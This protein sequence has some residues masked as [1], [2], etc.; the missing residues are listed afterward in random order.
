MEEHTKSDL[1][2]LVQDFVRLEG[3][4][5][6]GIATTGTL[7]GGPPS[8]NIEY[9]LDRARSVVSF[10]VGLDTDSI[11][12]YLSKQDRRWFEREMIQANVIASGIALHLTNYL[13]NKGHRAEPV[14]ANL[15]Y[16]LGEGNESG[17]D[18]TTT[19]YPD[20]AHRYVA[21]RAGLGH[22]GKSGNF[23][24]PEYGAAVILG[25]VVTDA[26]LVP[27]PPLPPEAN[28][29]DGCGLCR[30]ACV[31]GFM[32]FDGEERVVLGGEEYTY[33]R[34]RNLARCDLVCGGYTGLSESGAWSTWSPGRFTIPEKR[35]DIPEAYDR[36][37]AAHA[38]WPAAPG[39]RL[40]HYSDV[41]HRVACAH[42]Q[43][44][45]APSREER[46]ERFRMLR[47]SGV[48]V[49]NEDGSLE[50]VRPEKAEERLKGMTPQ[51]RRLYG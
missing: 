6:V 30:A 49:Q 27:T 26:R 47:Q 24:M 51:R 36:I 35:E 13:R 40:F 1:S 42:C 22:L 21:V 3:A 38:Q 34:R 37:T 33:S 41:V 2:R 46:K 20:L 14:A 10:A 25:G 7:A 39:G 23:I 16:R 12:P 15:V 43:A 44:I 5:A 45:C 19:V 18:P 32:D 9:V 31:S 29:C 17:Y 28:Y 4:A 11:R 50:A 48:V 8:T